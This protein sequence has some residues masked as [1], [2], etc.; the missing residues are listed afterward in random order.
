MPIMRKKY[1]SFFIAFLLNFNWVLAQT[2]ETKLSAGIGFDGEPNMAVN[3]NNP[4]HMVVAWMGLTLSGSTTLITIKTRATFD[5]GKTWSSIV[6]LPHFASKWGSADPTMVFHR[7][8]KLY[9]AYIDYRQAVD[10]GGVY[11]FS[12]SNGGLA[13]NFESQV[14]DGRESAKLPLDRP[15]MAI[16][17]SGGAYDGTLYIT[18]KPAPWIPAPN[19]PYLKVSSDGKTWSA[20]RFIDTTGFL[21]GNF[22]QAPMATPAVN[23]NGKF[24]A[25]YP[26]YLASQNVYGQMYLAS[27]NSKGAT[28]QYNSAV[29]NPVSAGDTNLKSG[30]LLLAHPNDPNA[31]IFTGIEGRN[32][33]AD[34]FVYR[35]NN[36]GKKWNAGV[37]VNDDTIGNGK[38]QDL[39]W[40]NWGKGGNLAVCWRDRRNSGKGFAQGADCYCTV[41]TDSG[42]SFQKNIRMTANTA[43]F[44][45]VLYQSGNDFMSC[46]LNG[47]T[48]VAV[49]G[50]V[51]NS[52]LEIWESSVNWKKTTGSV[53]QLIVSESLLPVNI[54]PQPANKEI[55][56]EIA[57]KIKII[58]IEIFDENGKCI[59]SVPT[60]SI[61]TLSVQNIPAG[62]YF[63]IVKSAQGLF[64][65][66]IEIIH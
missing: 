23:A 30:Y 13:W 44:H 32:G 54:W 57:E 33:D 6:A 53:P 52:K 5:G 19:R 2:T 40:A 65:K 51:R 20:T 66:K 63:F 43:A 59:Q 62:N 17:N 35:T 28:F 14:L 3:P 16:D 56:Y 12:S 24:M 38:L 1:L 42:K 9:L 22:I 29:S 8:G 49:W 46:A 55:Q 25:V 34:V 50:D 26:S 45:N 10:S 18:T 36:A 61:G 47:D 60:E 39:V 48:L 31:A 64:S 7:T 21:V 58:N 15:W 27:S 37:R 41:S 11:L 4:R